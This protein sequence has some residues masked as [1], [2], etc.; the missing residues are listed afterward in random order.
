MVSNRTFRLCTRFEQRPGD[1][2]VLWALGDIIAGMVSYVEAGRL[3]LCYNG[4]GDQVR[5]PAFDLPPGRHEAV[6]EYEALGARRGRGRLMVD[7]AER[8]AWTELSPTLMFGPFEGFDVGIDR[9]APVCLDVY[10]RHGAFAYT[11]SIEDVWIYP[12]APAPDR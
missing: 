4:F 10:Q 12:G 9:R 8:V 2:G 5:F 6:L 1:E 3:H 11:G 7:D